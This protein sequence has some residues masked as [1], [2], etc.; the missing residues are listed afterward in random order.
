MAT[1]VYYGKLENAPRN[2][3]IIVKLDS[4]PID[5]EN[6]RPLSKQEKDFLAYLKKGNFN[7]EETAFIL[8][9]GTGTVPHEVMY[10]YD[11]L[12]IANVPVTIANMVFVVGRGLKK[13]KKE[14][15]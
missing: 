15:A 4:K 3:V 7:T 14:D 8:Y 10:A 9:A 2:G 1:W 11:N 13:N 12:A 5:K 6:P